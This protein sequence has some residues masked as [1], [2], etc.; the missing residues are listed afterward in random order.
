MWAEKRRPAGGSMF[1]GK[2]VGRGTAIQPGS[3]ALTRHRLRC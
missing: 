1:L 2:S 3:R